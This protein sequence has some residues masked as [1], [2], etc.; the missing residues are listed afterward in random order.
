[1]KLSIVV[2]V[3]ADTV[4]VQSAMDDLVECGFSCPALASEQ[5]SLGR[6]FKCGAIGVQEVPTQLFEL[7]AELP[8]GALF[9]VAHS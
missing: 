1:M 8:F 7:F 5:K 4:A 9:F 6:R 3:D 2:P